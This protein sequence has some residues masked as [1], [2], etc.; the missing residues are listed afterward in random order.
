MIDAW[1]ILKASALNWVAH[2]DARQGAALAYYSIFSLGPLLI[3]AVFIAGLF[4]GHDAVRGEIS[5]TITGLL[6][7][8]G[9]SAISAMLEGASQPSQG[10]LPAIIGVATLI[11]ASVGV[12]VQLKEALN[13]VWEVQPPKERGVWQFARTYVF[14]FP[15]VI[16]VG[17]L[18]LVS[19]L[20]TAALTAISKYFGTS[21]SVVLQP[22]ALLSSFAVITL[23]F[24]AMLKWL[25]EVQIPWR[26]IWPGAILTATL[27]E[28]GKFLIGL[29]IG[30]QGLESTFGA[31]ASLVVVL[32]WVYYT[33]QI[34]LMGAEFTRCYSLANRPKHKRQRKR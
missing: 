7:E 32:I 2:N 15:A 9:S 26:D 4:F 17:F 8:T 5:L 23:L 1:K 16:A 21:S 20:I 25:P 34:V 12:V 18:L 11:F 30:S 10:V 13:I 22:V 33:A 28:I 29:Y 24:A 3:I 6:G 31:G 19:L 14:S 27:F